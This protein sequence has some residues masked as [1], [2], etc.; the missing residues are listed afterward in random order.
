MP[1]TLNAEQQELLHE[2][3][4]AF[5]A[6]LSDEARPRYQ[7]LADAVQ[8]GV[9][10][11]ETLEPVGNLLE[12]GLQTGRIRAMHRASGE[13]ALLRLFGQTPA[14]KALAD[15]TSDV[16]KALAQLAEQ[17]IE[18]MRVVTRVPGTYL[19]QITTDSHEMTLRFGPDGP[20]VESVALGS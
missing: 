12:A 18:S 9:L 4:S 3:V 10:P 8:E 6:L 19:L 1:V 16:N 14:G 5:L 13:Q 17:Q 15:L 20:G 2:E 11:D 7:S